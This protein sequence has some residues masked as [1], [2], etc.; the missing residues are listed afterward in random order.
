MD[1]TATQ[2]HENQAKAQK[3]KAT[4]PKGVVGQAK[5]ALNVGSKFKEGKLLIATAFCLDLVVFIPYT[6]LIINPFWSLTLYLHFGPK[7]KGGE[8]IKLV[9]PSFIE[10]LISAIFS[11]SFFPNTTT[12][13]IRIAAD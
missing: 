12:T 2:L 6:G 1:D 11:I 4:K 9:I 8:L 5:D 13:L 10:W 3:D 7:S